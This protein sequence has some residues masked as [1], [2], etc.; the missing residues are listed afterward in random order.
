MQRVKMRHVSAERHL[1]ATIDETSLALL[2][3]K[4]AGNS[5]FDFGFSL[6]AF[7][8]PTFELNR[9]ILF[10]QSKSYFGIIHTGSENPISTFA[11]SRKIVFWHS[12]SYFDIRTESEN[13]I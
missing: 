8:F 13:P 1:F 2:F 10:W 7:R 3:A 11:L 6:F 5:W 4:A 12:K 9:K